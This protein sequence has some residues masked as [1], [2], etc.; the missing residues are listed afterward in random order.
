MYRHDRVCALPHFNIR[1]ETGAKL[2]D[3]HRYDMYRNW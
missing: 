1:K 3:E 2:D